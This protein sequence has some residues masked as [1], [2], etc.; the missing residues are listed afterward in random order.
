MNSRNFDKTTCK[1]C[2]KE[3]IW[4]RTNQGGWILVDTGGSIHYDDCDP[5]LVLVT[6]AGL[7]IRVTENRSRD[8]EGEVSHK[9]TCFNREKYKGKNY[10]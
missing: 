6:D 9:E 3:C 7:V 4:R 10:E 1:D 8:I 2:G 5:G